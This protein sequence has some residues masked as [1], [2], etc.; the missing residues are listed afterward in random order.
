MCGADRDADL[1]RQ[2]ADLAAPILALFGTVDRVI[3]RRWVTS[4]KELMPNC[5]LVYFVYDAG[6]AIA[7]DWPEAFTEVVTDPSSSL[8]RP[9]CDPPLTKILVRRSRA[10]H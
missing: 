8:T 7:T 6:G 4:N 2:L 5:H 9:D 10:A 3:C 1:E